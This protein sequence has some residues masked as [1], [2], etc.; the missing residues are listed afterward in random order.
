[1]EDIVNPNHGL[2]NAVVIAHIANEEFDLVIGQGDAHIL[3]FLLV[4]AEHPDF[5]DIG[6]EETLQYRI[7]KRTSTAGNH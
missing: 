3:L 7:T 4:P 2:R 5:L 6:I 1:M